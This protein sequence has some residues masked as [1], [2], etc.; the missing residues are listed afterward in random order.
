M[1]TSH[2]FIFL[3]CL[4]LVDI[5]LLYGYFLYTEHG[6]YQKIS[7][8]VITPVLPKAGLIQSF[9]FIVSAVVFY[10]FVN[11]KAWFHESKLFDFMLFMTGF[12][13]IGFIPAKNIVVKVIINLIQLAAFVFFMLRVPDNELLNKINL[14][15]EAAKVLS[16]LVWF[17]VF[18]LSCLLNKW[19][20]I[21]YEQAFYIGLTF[22]IAPFTNV[23]VMLVPLLQFGGILF[24][25]ILMLAPFFYVLNYKLPLPPAAR[26]LFCFV[27]TGLSGLMILTGNWGSAVLLL[28]Y[29]LFEGVVILYRGIKRILLRSNQ[30]LSFYETL[31]SYGIPDKTIVNFILR[32]NILF[33]ALV[34]FSIDK[35]IQAQVALISVLLY[36]KFYFNVMNPRSSKSSLFALGR[37]LKAD[38]KNT[39]K[40]TEKSI[41]QIKEMYAAKKEEEKDKKE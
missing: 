1:I 2:Y 25:I 6:S 9:V 13:L 4:V 40:E 23:P 12:W 35:N 37:Q 8:D 33:G 28:S 3:A 31:Q 16:A 29:I 17:F 36:L 30:P 18:K 19:E 11:D 34:L 10:F 14:P 27:I 41:S 5:A 15:P 38:A 24:P 39:I 32:R 22:V 26:D 21:I 7:N 20:G